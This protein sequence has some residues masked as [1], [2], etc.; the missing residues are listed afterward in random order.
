M[1]KILKKGTIAYDYISDFERLKDFFAKDYRKIE[2]SKREIDRES[3]FG[4][5]REY[6][7]RIEAEDKV[8]ENLEILLSEDT[9]VVVSGQQA[10]IFTGP[11]FTIYKALTAIVLCERLKKRNIKC[12]PLFWNASE[13]H[14][15]EEIASTYI[16]KDN[17]PEKLELKGKIEKKSIS[18]IKTG[19]VNVFELIENM[20]ETTS[21]SEFKDFFILMLKKEA[22]KS[23]NLGE[24]FSRIM[25]RLFSNYG[26][27]LIEPHPLRKFMPKFCERLIENPTKISKLVKASSEKL[28]ERGYKPKLHKVLG[29]CNLFLIQDGRRERVE[30]DGSKFRVSE[31]V[32]K[33]EEFEELLHS[34][35]D[36][37]STNVV[38][39]PVF[40]DYLLPTLS[41]VAG[42][43][44]ISYFAQLRKV[45][46]FFG[47][48]M[49]VIYPRFGATI[50]ERK[51]KKI[52]LKYN[53][54]VFELREFESQ[55]SRLLRREVGNFDDFSKEI[56]KEFDEISNYA[57]SIDPNLK[58]A[59]LA[60]QKRIENEL[61]SL[62]SK[63]LSSVKMK[64]RILRSQI[65]K[66]HNNLFPTSELQERRLNVFY[67]L[68]KFGNTFIDLLKKEFEKA[69]AGDHILVYT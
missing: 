52:L 6:N 20:D 25:S 46:E 11:L 43:S 3:L 19:E 45:Y 61:F 49:P 17:R 59:T 50:L 1:N 55:I 2:I 42:S 26:L 30:F 58:R 8:F 41:Y 65:E 33:R 38:T 23:T 40:Q 57:E 67:Y 24:Y 69:E 4:V 62:K 7:K 13:D 10:G 48:K 9:Y 56:L 31:R 5:L 44:E 28:R 68:T 51:I 16:L 39:R 66:A 37:F 29:S 22:E 53:L 34:E 60:S 64:N 12:V 27:I 63:F 47:V 21:E 35:I 32:Y 18:D 15:F 36:S 54:E 14:D